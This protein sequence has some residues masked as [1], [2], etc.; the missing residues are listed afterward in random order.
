[1]LTN[2]ERDVW[3]SLTCGIMHIT[4]SLLQISIRVVQRYVNLFQ[5]IQYTCSRLKSY[6]NDTAKVFY[7]TT[8]RRLFRVIPLNVQ[9][10]EWGVTDIQRRH[11]VILLGVIYARLTTNT[12]TSHDGKIY[13]LLMKYFALVILLIYLIYRLRHWKFN[14]KYTL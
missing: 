2:R 10:K 13:F 14:Y 7:H 1:M 9:I 5:I 12:T 11:L 4:N 8:I 3:S 6:C